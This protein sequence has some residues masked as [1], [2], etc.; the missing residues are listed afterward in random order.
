[1]GGRGA[2]LGVLGYV[3]AACAVAEQQHGAQLGSALSIIIMH[4]KLL[5]IE[6]ICVKMGQNAQKFSRLR[7]AKK[8]RLRRGEVRLQSYSAPLTVHRASTPIG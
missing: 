3:H 7:R 4:V 1:M 2:E 8:S 6:W 5:K